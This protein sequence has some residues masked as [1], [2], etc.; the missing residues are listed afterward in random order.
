MQNLYMTHYYYT[1]TDPWQNIMNLPEAE[2]FRVA[3]ELA[4]A[5]PG[6]QSF[7][8]FADFS[9]Y[10][11][12]RKKADQFV[13]DR[14]VSLSGKPEL[15][16]PYCFC[17][18][19]S[20][21]LESWFSNGEKL[22]LGLAGIP[23]DQV[24]FT[25]GDS[26]ALIGK[27]KEPKVMTKSMLLSEIA[28]CGSYEAFLNKVREECTYVEVQLWMR[29]KYRYCLLDLDG[30]LTD[31]GIGITNSVMHALGKYDLKVKDRSELYFFIG[32]PLADSFR[33]Y[34]DRFGI[35][36]GQEEQAVAFYR[37]YFKD[38]GIFENEVYEGIPEVLQALKEKGVKVA[39]A[40]SKPYEFAVRILEHFHLRQYFD[41]LGAATM[42]GRISRKADVISELLKE[43]GVGDRTEILMVGDRNQD[44]DGAKAN[45]LHS[46]GVLWGYGS[47]EELQTA[48]ADYVLSKPADLAGLF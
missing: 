34:F 22:V 13:R 5:H 19:E 18:G 28:A 32:P 2:A 40:T 31:P 1:G 42:D 38:K 7:G 8:R 45:S 11:P 33:K 25:Y 9:N 35:G 46:A 6:T 21:Y 4:G 15:E 17:L 16:H 47:E 41:Y 44:V 39:L 29:P 3:E 24:S 26:C 14:F 12:L 43:I 36:A 27:G 30:T 10:Y 37:E 23:D 20:E 48:G